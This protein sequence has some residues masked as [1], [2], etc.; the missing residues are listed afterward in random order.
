MNKLDIQEIEETL[1]EPEDNPTANWPKDKE[2]PLPESPASLNIKFWADGYGIMLTM[3]HNDVSVLMGRFQLMLERIKKAG[4]KNKWDETS[5]VSARP[6][7]NPST[8]TTTPQTIPNCPYHNKPMTYKTGQYG[9]F[10]SCG[11]KLAD[12]TWCKYRP[13]KEVKGWTEKTVADPTNQDVIDPFN[14]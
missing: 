7:S 8:G 10:W 13:P 5:P 1:N 11:T 3:R 9:N 2:E 6:V 12:G 4:Y 14:K